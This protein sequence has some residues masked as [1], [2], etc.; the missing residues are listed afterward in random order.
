MKI[1]AE[2]LMGQPQKTNSSHGNW[3]VQRKTTLEDVGG[4]KREM[5][6]N[7]YFF[8]RADALRTISIYNNNGKYRA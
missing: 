4:M 8:R 2:T 6:D 5:S 7:L 3:Y 1:I